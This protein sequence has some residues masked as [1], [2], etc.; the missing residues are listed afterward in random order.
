MRATV[1]LEISDRYMKMAVAKAFI[2]Q[3]Q[4]TDCIVRDIFGFDDKKISEL[5]TSILRGLK[6][7]PGPLIISL[8]RD[9]VT[10]RNLHLPST[11]KNEIEQML[12]LHIGRI[13]P[14]K[15]E[16]VVFNYELLG[17]DELDYE[18]IML[19]I[20]QRDIIKRQLKILEAANLFTDN[21]VLSS[22]GVHE[23]LLSSQ[24]AQITGD[25]LYLALDFDANFIDFIVFTRDNI[26]FDRSITMELKPDIQEE[27]ITKLIGEVRQ[28][29]VMFH[30][31][32]TNKNPETIFLCGAAL[33]AG[34]QEKFRA[35]L[36]IP[37]KYVSQAH[38]A[39]NVSFSAVS[40]LALAQEPQHSFSFTL[41]EMQIKK[42]V[43]DRS[44]ELIIIGSMAIYFFTAVF[45]LFM[46]RLTSQQLYLDRI[47]SNNKLIEK[48]MGELVGDYRNVR[49]IKNYIMERKFLLALLAELQ[50]IT[51]PDI[52]I[53]TITVDEKH[54]VSIKGKSDY[55]SG[56]FNYV[57][58]L[59]NSKYF[60]SA[61]AK[62]AR[63]RK[64]EGKEIAYFEIE[65]QFAIEEAGA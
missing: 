44:K 62:T 53:D 57:T 5:I 16:E 11:N 42:A 23:W 59:E 28:S 26:I 25:G 14:S 50:K 60:N 48:D 54:K 3:R 8:P 2:K 45:I 36:D 34:L 58:M 49:F 46:G 15:K 33:A 22:C 41:P 17:H 6:V 9:K 31:E 37:I 65:F 19:A 4:L 20:A 18:K 51:P 30:N 38:S 63:T 21:V 27:Q 10:V 64:I 43:K 40:A 7:N 12:Q 35:E 52:T 13:V 24:K 55:L 1:V 61:S 56:A 47:A 29:L 39:M 32:E